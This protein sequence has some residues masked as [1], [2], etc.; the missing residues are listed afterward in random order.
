MKKAALSLFLLIAIIAPSLAGAEATSGARAVAPRRVVIVSMP[1]I[2]WEDHQ[3]GNT[4]NLAEIAE[5]WSVAAMSTRTVGPRTDEASAFATLGAG[6]RARALGNDNVEF[7]P[8]TVASEEEGLVVEEMQKVRDDNSEDLRYGAEP[9]ALGE[10]LHRGQLTTAVVGNSDGG[11]VSP[12][13]T[14]RVTHGLMRRRFAGLALADSRGRIDLGDVGDSLVIDDPS[15]S[16]GYRSQPDAIVGAFVDAR[17]RADVLLVELADT[18]R[19]GL[20]LYAEIDTDDEIPDENHPDRIRAVRR[21][22]ELLGRI[23]EHIELERDALIVLGTSGLGP[24]LRER[25]TVALV[26]GAG[27]ERSGWV[28]SATTK[29][30][31]VVTLA[32]IAPGLLRLLGI[33]VADSMTGRAFNVVPSDENDR[34]GRLV[35]LQK[36]ALFHLRWLTPFFAALVLAQAAL[37]LVA[38]RPAARAGGRVSFAL[39]AAT[40]GFLAVPAA[41]FLWHAFRPEDLGLLALPLLLVL[42]AA[43]VV[44]SLAG[45]WRTK[46][47][48]PPTVIC[49]ATFLIIGVDL[50]LGANL[51]LSSLIGY[52]PIIAGRF[53]GIGNLDFAVFGTSAIFAASAAAAFFPRRAILISALLGL[54]AAFI[55]GAPTIGAD[56]GGLLSLVVGFGV[57][58]LLLTGR[59]LSLRRIVLL[60]LAGFAVAMAAG[61][62]DYLRPVDAQTHLGRFIAR[63]LEGGAAAVADIIARK[64]TANWA[65]ATNSILSLSVPIAGVFL[66]FLLRRPRGR[67][68]LG[69]AT[70]PG[71]K[72]GLLAAGALNLAGFVVNDSGIAVPAM[73]LAV[74][75]P[76]CLAT[77][78]AVASGSPSRLEHDDYVAT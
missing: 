59:R 41:T 28:T 35:Q 32:D 39:R 71:L 52:S 26:A 70:E 13:S 64:A 62:V 55:N 46:P 27:A 48:G 58:M 57:L 36:A 38:W 73:G 10:H 34:I 49:V 16:N 30:N 53:F 12:E 40:L 6:N 11:F 20:V 7:L 45:P 67:L 9:G 65:V 72:A 17:D 24:S 66:Y 77:I 75:V 61:F 14:E 68:H 3:A 33:E 21:D 4:P 18:L 15:T 74:G 29:R 76:Y 78:L 69:L 8:A 31:G 50:L 1:G 2:T 5:D 43:M 54:T 42:C 22:D 51:Q 23:V 47:S 37:Y 63:L 25:L 44:V 19:E 60:A 56:F